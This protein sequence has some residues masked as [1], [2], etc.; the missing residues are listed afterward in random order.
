MCVLAL[1][2]CFLEIPS[3]LGV[4]RG[5][6]MHDWESRHDE[7]ILLFVFALDDI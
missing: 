6:S 4:A 7:I 1:E 5:F 3:E 2:F